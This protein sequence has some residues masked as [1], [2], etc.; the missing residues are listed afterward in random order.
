MMA[1][2]VW[3][4]DAQFEKFSLHRQMLLDAHTCLM[5]GILFF[6]GTWHKG[7]IK[8]RGA[9][10]TGCQVSNKV[11]AVETRKGAGGVSLNWRLLS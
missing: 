5:W 7:L 3:T 9:R 8:E 11:L 1:F 4:G 6:Q 2:H 10:K